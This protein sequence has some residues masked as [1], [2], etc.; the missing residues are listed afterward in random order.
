[1]KMYNVR[2]KKAEYLLEVLHDIYKALSCVT[3]SQF[4]CYC[5][6]TQKPHIISLTLNEQ[7]R[8]EHLLKGGYKNGGS[9]DGVDLKKL[10]LYEHSS[11]EVPVFKNLTN[12]KVSRGGVPF[13]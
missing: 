12:S 3:L 9:V 4:F 7:E 6:Q 5:T 2:F 8:E 10:S 11:P 1:M 13:F